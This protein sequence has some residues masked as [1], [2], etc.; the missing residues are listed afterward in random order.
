[1]HFAPDTDS[2]ESCTFSQILGIEL[3]FRN[4]QPMTRTEPWLPHNREGIF[5]LFPQLRRYYSIGKQFCSYISQNV[6]GGVF[7]RSWMMCTREQDQWL[8][9]GSGRQG[10]ADDRV[11]TKTSTHY[12]GCRPHHEANTASHCGPSSAHPHIFTVK[13]SSL[14]HS[15]FEPLGSRLGWQCWWKNREQVA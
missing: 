2:H 1:M 6:G 13:F 10:P 11:H 15:R 12:G 5:S 7:G 4:N 14:C 9:G 8:H 3:N